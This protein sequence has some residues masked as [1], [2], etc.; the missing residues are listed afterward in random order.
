MLAI[1]AFVTPSITETVRMRLVT[2]TRFVRVFT[3][4]ALGTPPSA[5][6]AMTASVTLSITVTVFDPR[7]AT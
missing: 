7:L 3:A 1:T 5:I 2:Y 6:V 4:T